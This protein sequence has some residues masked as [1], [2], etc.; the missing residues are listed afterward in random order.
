MIQKAK[1]Y[2]TKGY[3]HLFHWTETRDLLEGKQFDLVLTETT[4][5]DWRAYSKTLPSF[6]SGATLAIPAGLA[7]STTHHIIQ[8]IYLNALIPEQLPQDV[9]PLL[10]EGNLVFELIGKSGFQLSTD[11]RT[12]TPAEVFPTELARLRN[13]LRGSEAQSAH[14]LALLADPK[15]QLSRA[16]RRIWEALVGPSAEAIRTIKTAIAEAENA[17]N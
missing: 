16:Q 2:A 8:I 17:K 5:P 9:Q 3:P 4:H 14:T 11:Y 13:D 15:G 1:R 6:G 12:T 10:L 7:S